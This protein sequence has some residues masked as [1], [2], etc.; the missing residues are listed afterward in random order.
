ME[1]LFRETV[2]FLS[3]HTP[4]MEIC[5]VIYDNLPAQVVRLRQFLET[6]DRLQSTIM[7]I[8]CFDPMIN[9]IF[10]HTIKIEVP[11]DVFT[12]LSQII[13]IVHSARSI[14]VICLRCPRLNRTKWVYLVRV[15]AF[16]IDHFAD[17]QTAFELA[18]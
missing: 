18:D 15:L 4:A 9:L 8:P 2:K 5:G 14:I 17:V 13:R 6:A 12:P 7:H 16:L 1:E 10:R 3:D 11:S